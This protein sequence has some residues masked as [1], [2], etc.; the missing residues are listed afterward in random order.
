MV[1]N[2]AGG[3]GG[4][5]LGGIRADGEKQFFSRFGGI[6]CDGWILRAGG[7]GGGH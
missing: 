1:R 3:G 7:G 5:N 2:W 6:I 4:D